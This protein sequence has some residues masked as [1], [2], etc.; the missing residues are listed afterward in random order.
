MLSESLKYELLTLMA[1]ATDFV[2]KSVVSLIIGQPV[3]FYIKGK[4]IVLSVF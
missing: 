3:I 1:A 2:D 4:M